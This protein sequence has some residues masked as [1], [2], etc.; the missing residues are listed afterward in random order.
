M[1]TPDTKSRILEVAFQLFHEQGYHATGISTILREAGVNAGSLY[2]FFPSKE[3]LLIGVLEYALSAMSFVVMAPAEAATPDPVARVFALL[4]WYRSNMN[5]WGCKM[6][7][8]IG[9]L[10]LEVSDN[11]AG[12]RTLIDANFRNWAD[13]VSGWLHSDSADLPASVNRRQLA[14]FVLTVMEGGIMQARAAGNIKP[15]DDSIAQLRAYFDALRTLATLE[16]SPHTDR[17]VPSA[18]SSRSAAKPTRTA[19]GAAPPRPSLSSPGATRKARRKAQKK[20][21]PESR[22]RSPRRNRR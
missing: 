11:D 3:A 15:F 22:T 10:A 8:P 16:H 4:D 6:G 19:P 21:K 18:G 14:Y 1:T 12:V 5:S 7:C 2:H 9:N 20:T 17:I 13:H